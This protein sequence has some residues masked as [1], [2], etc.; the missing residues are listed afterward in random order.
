MRSKTS[1]KFVK[2]FNSKR[3]YLLV[4]VWLILILS[5][6]TSIAGWKNAPT[7][8]GADKRMCAR[9]AKDL[10]MDPQYIVD[11]Y[12]KQYNTPTD[13]IYGHFYGP[14]DY[15]AQFAIEYLA[16]STMSGKYTWL[17]DKNRKYFY[18]YLLATEYPDYST[19]YRSPKI[20]LDC[21]RSTGVNRDFGDNSHAYGKL[22]TLANERGKDGRYYLIRRTRV[23][24]D[25]IP[26]PWPQTAAFYLGAMTHYITE[27]AHPSHASDVIST[28]HGWLEREVGYFTT[29]EHYRTN[30]YGNNFFTIDL[31]RILGYSALDLKDLSGE[32]AVNHMTAVTRNNTENFFDGRKGTGEKNFE[33]FFEFYDNH[34]YGFS[35]NKVGRNNEEYK[36]FFDRIEQLLN[37]AVYF[38]ACALKHYLK[39]FD[40][41]VPNCEEDDDN[42]RNSGD[43]KLPPYPEVL[44]FISRYGLFFVALTFAGIIGRKFFAAKFR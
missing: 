28:F 31:E 42:P 22:H 29:L 4:A 23:N 5:L 20:I 37:W 38:T 16:K 40:G 24:G 15:L 32:D 3:L 2:I 30:H 26:D 44:D 34:S 41:V 33:Y 27:A 6:S 36:P 35:F 12:I 14:H 10:G 18:T 39:D 9:N 11:F 43:R 25:L 8:V 13:P 21:G 1:K 7:N 19:S 17:A